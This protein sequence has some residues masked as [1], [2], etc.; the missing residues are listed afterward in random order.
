MSAAIGI[1]GGTFD[2]IH[3]G[4]LA[5]AE[6]AHTALGL[7]RVILVPAAHQPLKSGHHGAA[8]ADRLAM[9]HLASGD[10]AHF[11]VSAIEIE[12]HGPSYTI[13]TLRSL[14]GLG[15]TRLCFIL[16]ADA[17]IDLPRW[18]DVGE[19][20]ELAQIV[21]VARPG[22]QPD[23][24]QITARLPALRERLVLLE[25]PALDISS[26]N[27]RQRIA[28]GRPIRYLVPDAIAAYISEHGLYHEPASSRQ[29]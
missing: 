9:T 2:P 5:I 17:L 6:E 11:A 10:N 23:V 18:R 29:Q 24:E 16:G 13:D 21:A 7:E 14:H 26:T 8:P 20:L 15:M 28:Q 25:G 27:L 22:Y 1:L 19:V 12:R 3:H 4:H